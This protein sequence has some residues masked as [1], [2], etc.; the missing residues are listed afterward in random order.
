MR[1]IPIV[2]PIPV[3]YVIEVVKVLLD[4]GAAI[5]AMTDHNATALHLAAREGHID[6]VKVLLERGASSC[7]NAPDGMVGPHFV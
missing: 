7:V 2:R 3:S 5:D 1:P 4:R 6:I